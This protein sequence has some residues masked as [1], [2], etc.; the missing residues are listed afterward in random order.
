[1]TVFE[2]QADTVEAACKMV[3]YWISTTPAEKLSWRPAVEGSSKTR[4]ILEFTQE[5]VNLN[6]SF[7]SVFQG[8][9]VSLSPEES[10]AGGG[11][12]PF[13]GSGEVAQRELVESAVDLAKV[14][15]GLD[16]SCFTRAYDL[17]FAKFS[18][19]MIL[20]IAAANTYYHGG[21]LNYVQLLYGDAEMHFPPGFGE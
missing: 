14:I 18:G 5:C 6:R 3:A 8:N 2:W 7:A 11:E 15:R 21:Q 10:M 20:R 19:A 16:E 17:G 1:M 4:S 9:P 13:G 12:T